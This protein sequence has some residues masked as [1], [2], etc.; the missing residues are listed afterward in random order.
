MM[1]LKELEKQG[2]LKMNKVL[3]HPL[4]AVSLGI[5]DGE[6]L[7]DLEY[8]EDY[9]ADVDLNLVMTGDGDVIEVQGT[10][11]RNPFSRQQ[12]NKMLDAGFEGIQAICSAGDTFLSQQS[13]GQ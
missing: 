11:E 5:V 6:I 3:R 8:E 10:A 7:L 12:L 9:R 13:S 1:T 2:H 4:A